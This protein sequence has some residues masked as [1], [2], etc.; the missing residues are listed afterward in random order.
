MHSS[1]L[2]ENFVIP[3]YRSTIRRQYYHALPV[4]FFF[5]LLKSVRFRDSYVIGWNRL[6]F[7]IL[8]H[9][10]GN[11]FICRQR[12]HPPFNH[13]WV[14]N[15]SPVLNVDIFVMMGNW[16]DAS[17][18]WQNQAWAQLVC[19]L[20]STFLVLLWNVPICVERQ[21]LWRTT[22]GGFKFYGALENIEFQFHLSLL[23]LIF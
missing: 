16:R 4:E 3:G 5:L 11:F 20:W 10:N 13:K 1:L 22:K 15:Y 7:F 12:S 6:F 8:C 23:M 17:S 18:Q 9:V 19:S 2:P 14:K 21:D